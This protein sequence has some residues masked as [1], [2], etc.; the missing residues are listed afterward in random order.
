MFKVCLYRSPSESPSH[1][2]AD[3]IVLIANFTEELQSRVTEWASTIRVRGMK[4]NVGMKSDCHNQ[5]K[6]LK[7]S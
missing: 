4:I 7:S 5:G 6:L 3:D 1:V 2:N